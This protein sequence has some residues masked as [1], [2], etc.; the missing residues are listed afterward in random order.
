VPT[1]GLQLFHGSNI[2]QLQN[3][4]V[5]ALANVPKVNNLLPSFAHK[6]GLAHLHRQH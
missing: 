5:I 3:E 4:L 1:E 6:D 2:I